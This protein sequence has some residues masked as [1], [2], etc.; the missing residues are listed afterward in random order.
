MFLPLAFFSLNLTGYV[1]MVHFHCF[2]EPT[3]FNF[4]IH[5]NNIKNIM[6]ST[7]FKKIS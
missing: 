1:N 3:N 2:S 6:I 5:K 4:I 7:H